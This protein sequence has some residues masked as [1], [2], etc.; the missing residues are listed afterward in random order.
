MRT[1][2]FSQSSQNTLSMLS[3]Y[4]KYK[5]CKL[6]HNRKA[7]KV[8]MQEYCPVEGSCIQ[9]SPEGDES[10]PAL[11]SDTRDLDVFSLPA[12]GELLCVYSLLMSL[13]SGRS[14]CHFF[15]CFSRV[16]YTLK[17]MWQISHLYTSLPI[18][19]WVFIWRVSLELWAH[20]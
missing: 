10:G 8:L 18:C 6:L 1:F 15:M 13:A 5:T 19:P 9:L 20:A 2:F 4:K 11:S 14:L 17:G 12:E 16:L 3:S 7:Q